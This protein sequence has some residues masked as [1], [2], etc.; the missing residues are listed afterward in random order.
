VTYYAAWLYQWNEGEVALG[1]LL[2]LIQEMVGASMVAFVTFIAGCLVDK[3]NDGI[4]DQF[5][6]GDEK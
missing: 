4:P 1:D 5:E 3:D 2:S 6:E